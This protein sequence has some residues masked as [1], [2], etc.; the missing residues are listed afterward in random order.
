MKAAWTEVTLPEGYRLD[1]REVAG[2]TNDEAAEAARAGAA[3]GWVVVAGRQLAGRG[4]RGSAWVCPPGEGLAFSV[5]MRPDE[6]KPLWPR[7][8]LAVGLAVAEGLDRYGIAAEVKWPNDVWVRDRKIAGILVEAGE[9]HVIAGVGINVG[10]TEFP[11]ALVGSSTSLA[12][13][14]GEPPELSAVLSSVLERLPIWQAKIGSEFGELL[15]RFRQ[16][17]ALT[18]RRIR[19]IHGGSVLTGTAAGIGD[20]GELLLDTEAGRQRIVQ[21]DEIRLL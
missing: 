15:R 1:Y 10:V 2:S 9:A 14:L 19:L 16:R 8:S 13:E 17:C 21:A 4:R 20:G 3:A 7:L 6:A 5:V 18:G 11:E 12:I